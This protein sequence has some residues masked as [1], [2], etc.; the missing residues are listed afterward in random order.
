M[1]DT[2]NIYIANIISEGEKDL[3]KIMETFNTLIE[4]AKRKN[5]TRKNKKKKKQ[6][7]KQNGGSKLNTT[8]KQI[9]NK[10]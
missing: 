6:K 2:D 10:F 3:Q 7:L 8:R 1:R 5:K 4:G 9:L